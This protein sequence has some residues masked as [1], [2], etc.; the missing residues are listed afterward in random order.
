MKYCKKC[1]E[2]KK[3]SEFGK[4]IRNKD[5][6]NFYCKNC[7]K[8]RNADLKKN[9]PEYVKKHAILYMNKNSE[10]I[11]EK[12]RAT[13]IRDREKRLEQGRNS[14]HKNKDK[15]AK[16]RQIKRCTPEGREKSRIRMQE[17]RKRFPEKVR[18]SVKKWQQTYKIRHNAHQKV[19][20]AIEDRILIRSNTCQECGKMGKTEG[21]HEDYNKP[22]DVI[23]LC[24]LCH[25]KKIE[26]IEV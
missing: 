22:L 12:S 14:Y 18:L 13:F 25:S 26:I 19:H 9:K 23:W 24:K 15:I 3:I 8:K 2:I 10:K 1:D 21:H 20:R 11:N 16:R 4:D 5:G 6:L 7:I 17:W